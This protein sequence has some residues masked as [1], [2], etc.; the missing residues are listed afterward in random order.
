MN[1]VR[2]GR[3]EHRSCG[4]GGHQEA[5]FGAVAPNRGMEASARPLAR[6]WSR[7]IGEA[8]LWLLVFFGFQPATA[9]Q[10]QLAE[11]ATQGFPPNPQP[12]GG[13]KLIPTRI[14][15]DAAQ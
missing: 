13:L 1:S 4:F 7:G 14:L 5:V 6:V 9:V 3:Q 8:V 15:Q 12:A 10:A 11:S 2:Q